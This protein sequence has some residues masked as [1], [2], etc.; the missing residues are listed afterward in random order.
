[1]SSA[2]IRTRRAMTLIEIM[3]V[4]A[5]L[6][7]IA[8]VAI[9][10]LSGLLDLQQ[11]GAAKELAQT[12]GWLSDEARLRNVTFR[13]AYNLDD[14][15]WKVEVGDPNTL[16]FATP[17]AREEAEEALRDRMSQ[18]TER[19]IAAGE[20]DEVL[21]DEDA[22]P[23]QFSGLNDPAFTAQ[24]ELP[25]GSRFGF[26]YTPQY[27]QDGL[28]P[29]EDGPP[30]DPEDATIAYSYIFPDGTAE[31]TIIRI[32]DID[33]PDDGWTL[34]MDPLTGNVRLDP[35]VRDPEDAFAWL[36]DEAP[37]IR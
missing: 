26:V 4:L 20:A 13:I 7:I 25:G 21:E 5:V 15:T 2:R 36:P 30:D 28:M 29:S 14:S 9:P 11:R 24:Q 6:A 16:V 19:E 33:D 10:S 18:F 17:E 35:D 27:G 31:H 22:G 37:E 32:V 12:L 1:M 8:A 3:V 34:E 23:G